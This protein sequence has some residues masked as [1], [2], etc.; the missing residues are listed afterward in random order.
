MWYEM[1]WS[2]RSGQVVLYEGEREM[3][4]CYNEWG[5]SSIIFC[6]LYM[7]GVQNSFQQGLLF[8]QITSCEIAKIIIW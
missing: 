5:N 6:F 3:K 7:K 1:V 4:V 8:Q 2:G